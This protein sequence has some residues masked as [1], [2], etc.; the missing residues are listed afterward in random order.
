MPD[1]RKY[2]I[3]FLAVVIVKSCCDLDLFAS[4][5]CVAA[6]MSDS[7]FLAIY[8][9]R[10]PTSS[11]HSNRDGRWAGNKIKPIPEG[12]RIKT[13]P[14]A[15]TSTKEILTSR[16]RTIAGDRISISYSASGSPVCMLMRQ[17][18]SVFFF[19]FFLPNEDN[20]RRSDLDFVLGFREPRVHADE[21]AEI[22]FFFLSS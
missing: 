4:G 17:N 13:G 7:Y 18:K 10:C 16:M 22:C 15:A 21:A 11:P 6:F 3:K 1:A 19:L 20:S 12:D 14:M 9:I 2:R 8:L 5:I